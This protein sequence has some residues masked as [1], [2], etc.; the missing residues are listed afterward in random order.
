MTPR[1]QTLYRSHPDRVRGSHPSAIHKAVAYRVVSMIGLEMWDRFPT[2]AETSL[3]G[4]KFRRGCRCSSDA[5]FVCVAEF[6]IGG[7]AGLN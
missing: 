3:A 6:E 5:F 2:R 4:I 7:I 1:H